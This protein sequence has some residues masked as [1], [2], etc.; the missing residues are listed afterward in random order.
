MQDINQE[1]REQLRHWPALFAKYAKPD[2]RKA[3]IQ[4]INTF[5]PF[6]ALWVLMYFSLSWSYWITL[7][8]AVVNAF[9][10]VRIFIIQHD[11]GHRSFL[12][13]QTA[14][15][16]IGWVCSLF[17]AIP[18]RYW[19]RV[20]DFHHGHSDQLEV[21][22][23]GD[24]KT[25]TVEQ[26]RQAGK[27]Q[28]FG[29]QLFR[30][31]PVTFV[32][33]PVVYL[34]WNNR[35]PLVRIN[36]WD[37]SVL[38]QQLNNLLLAAVYVG[39]GFWLGW[40]RFLLIQLPILVFFAII[41]V[42][43]FYVQHQHED[44]YKQWKDKWEYLLAAVRGSTFYK[45]PR[46]FNWLTGNIGYHHIHHLNS[47][48]PNYHLQWAHRENRFIE[49]YITTIRFGESLKCMFNKLWCEEEQRMISF[50]EFRQRERLRAA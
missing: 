10:M 1:I 35:L 2:T 42:W 50:R 29:Y 17:S 18:F 40:S 36:G 41:A 44:T 19:A 14:N 6:I 37:R 38:E 7:A 5:L 21:S 49:K 46:V 24:I 16:I 15:K 48:I 11:C 4:I 8:L 32:I 33:G 45:L 28:R 25:M 34:A 3:V 13:S 43:F 20:H 39:L 47:K 22:D 26:Y 30:L 23:I 12:K 31:P 27:W 9:F